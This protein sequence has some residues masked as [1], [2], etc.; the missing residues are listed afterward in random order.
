VQLRGLSSIDGLDPRDSD[1]ST[2]RGYWLW[3]PPPQHPGPS[4]KDPEV[5]LAL[6]LC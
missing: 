6:S 4:T 3:Y 1:D 5:D 2:G